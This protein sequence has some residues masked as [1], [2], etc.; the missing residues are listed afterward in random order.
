MTNSPETTLLTAAQREE[1]RER[2]FV[3]LRGFYDVE[4]EIAPVQRGIAGIIELLRKKYGM[5]ATGKVDPARFD[6]GYAE[7]LASDRKRGGEVYDAIKQIP[8]LLR[9]VATARHEQLFRELRDTDMPGIAAGGYGIRIDNPNE[10][11]FR[12]DWHQEYHAQ[13]R[14]T[15]GI[16]LWTSLVPVTE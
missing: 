11:R 9:L 3:C 4:Q 7:L 16:T 15:D 6:A 10:E 13:L 1:F 12:A 8:A 5:P 2:G 14:S